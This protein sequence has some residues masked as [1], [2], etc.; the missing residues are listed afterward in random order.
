VTAAAFPQG[1]PTR[2]VVRVVVVAQKGL[3]L[4]R[5]GTVGQLQ[6]LDSDVLGKTGRTADR[7][8]V[9]LPSACGGLRAFADSDTS[10]RTEVKVGFH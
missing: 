4:C 7:L 2:V 6:V 8:K 1:A 10:G 5:A 9:T 3:P